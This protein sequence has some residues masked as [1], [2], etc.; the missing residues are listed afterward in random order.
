MPLV[1]LRDPSGTE[2]EV[3]GP[4]CPVVARETLTVRRAGAKV[5]AIADGGEERPC[6]REVPADAR[7]SVGLRGAPG[8]GTSGARNLFV[9]RE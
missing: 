3:G 4:F 6:T 5:V 9:R 8:G 2:L 1:V 7:L